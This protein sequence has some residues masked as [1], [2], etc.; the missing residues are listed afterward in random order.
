MRNKKYKQTLLDENAYNT[1]V[2]A[3][4]VIQAKSNRKVTFSDVINEFIKKKVNFLKLDVDIQNYILTFVDQV[5]Q[6]KNVLGIMLFGSI[7]RGTFNSYSDIDVLVVVDGNVLT[8]FDKLE[9]IIKEIDSIRQ[10]LVT[11]GL[12]LYISEVILKKED[13]AEFRPFYISLLEEGITL[14]EKDGILTEFI[15]NLKKIR[16]TWLKMGNNLVLEWKE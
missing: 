14:Y 10:K 13:L 6:D 15:S 9:Q 1:L 4:A 5:K 3:K 8:Y 7:A 11:K 2:D 12:Y 16:Y